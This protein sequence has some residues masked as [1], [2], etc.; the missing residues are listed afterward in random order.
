MVGGVL[1]PFKMLVNHVVSQQKSIHPATEMCKADIGVLDVKTD[2]SFS[3]L[4]VSGGNFW[5]ADVLGYQPSRYPQNDLVIV[6]LED[7]QGVVRPARVSSKTEK[8]TTKSTSV[9][10]EIICLSLISLLAG[11]LL[12]TGTILSILQ[13][14]M[15]SSVLF[16]SYT[17][18]WA[19]SVSV[20]FAPMVRTKDKLDRRIKEDPARR[21][22]IYQRPEGGKIIF[23]AR[24]DTLETWARMTYTF[25]RTSRN[26]I[27]HWLWILS[28][29]IACAASVICMVN[30]A[31]WWQLA[32]LGTLA[33]ASLSELIITILVRRIQNIAVN[34]GEVCN[35]I[36][37]NETWSNA[38]VRSSLGV[39]EH[40]SLAKLDWIGFGRLPDIPVF[41]NLCKLLP[42]LRAGTTMNSDAV[43]AKLMQGE[44]ESRRGLAE[45]L[46]REIDAALKQ[47][48]TE[49]YVG[50][51][52]PDPGWGV[53]GVQFMQSGP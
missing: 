8:S 16:L 25:N 37:E 51:H 40:F 23:V 15:W 13:G 31:A 5:L 35:G 32:W 24:Q 11:L 12:L 39:A 19:A 43:V 2:I 46:S 48:K 10:F 44:D 47:V 17:S 53:G 18:H 3:E 21:H 9:R 30:M 49:G 6:H 50:E 33:L 34:Y 52:L 27:L 7:I 29:S 1:A 26:N 41:R 36:K 4:P 22:A 20:S 45:R 42:Q 28:G 14:D 38:I